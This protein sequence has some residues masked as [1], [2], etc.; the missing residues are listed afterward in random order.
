MPDEMDMRDE[1]RDPLEALNA[2][3]DDEM[4]GMHVEGDDAD[5]EEGEVDDAVV[6]PE[7]GLGL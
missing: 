7:I 1:E 5:K 6:D 2:E 4:E 3:E